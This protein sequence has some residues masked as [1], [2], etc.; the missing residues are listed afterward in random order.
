MTKNTFQA[1]VKFDDNDNY[2]PIYGSQLYGTFFSILA[3]LTTDSSNPNYYL[4][5]NAELQVIVYKG[6]LDIGITQAKFVPVYQDGTQDD[7]GGIFEIEVQAMYES[8][9]KNLIVNNIN[10][11]HKFPKNN[12]FLQ[13]HRKLKKMHP[14]G[15][16]IKDGIFD[17]EF[18]YREGPGLSSKNIQYVKPKP[19]EWGE[20]YTQGI[21]Y[22]GNCRTSKM[23]VI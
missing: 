20:P 9:P 13:V 2:Q 14:N 15:Q 23:M 7:F 8:K 22:I 6:T 4:L 1:Y 10:P 11:N 3:K 19:D 5:T 21:G 18:Y 16:Q 12:S 17:S